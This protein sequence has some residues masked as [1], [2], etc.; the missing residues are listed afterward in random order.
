MTCIKGQVPGHEAS[1]EK[2]VLSQIPRKL[3][4]AEGARRGDSGCQAKPCTRDGASG[5][6]GRARTAP[7]APSAALG[8]TAV[9]PSGPTQQASDAEEARPPRFLF[10]PRACRRPQAPS[11]SFGRP[12]LSVGAPRT[13]LPSEGESSGPAAAVVTVVVVVD[14]A[15]GAGWLGAATVESGSVSGSGSGSLPGVLLRG[16]GGESCRMGLR[17]GTARDF[18]PIAS[19]SASRERRP[20]ERGGRSARRCVINIHAPRHRLLRES[21]F[22]RR[23]ARPRKRLGA[24]T[25]FWYSPRGREGGLYP[26]W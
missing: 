5:S 13:P 2:L 23:S 26:W 22:N 3:C 15:A 21:A 10:L 20:A 1:D 11:S 6:V 25:L 9:L 12:H 19:P 7:P 17:P 24:P 8:P 16:P 4:K 18:F 14:G